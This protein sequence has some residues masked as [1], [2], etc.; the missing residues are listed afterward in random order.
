MQYPIWECYSCYFDKKIKI[1]NIT[2]AITDIFGKNKSILWF[3]HTV[4]GCRKTIA[5]SEEFKFMI[6][7]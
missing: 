5:C 4:L 6:N 2:K 1:E 3:A 7:K